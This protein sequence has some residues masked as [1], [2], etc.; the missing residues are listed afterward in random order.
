MVP[1]VPS[2]CGANTQTP[3][4]DS[5]M[6]RPESPQ[7]LA[8]TSALYPVIAAHFVYFSSGTSLI[9]LM[10]NCS[11]HFKRKDNCHHQ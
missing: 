3:G 6:K 7:S 10:D 1:I 9:T 2:S 8:N 11:G 5:W 4:T